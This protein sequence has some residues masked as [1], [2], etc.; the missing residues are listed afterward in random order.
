MTDRT[1]TF[2]EQVELDLRWPTPNEETAE[3]LNDHERWRTEL[4]RLKQA[5]LDHYKFLRSHRAELR[6]PTPGTSSADRA[7]DLDRRITHELRRLERIENRLSWIKQHTMP[8]QH[9][10][11]EAIRR[12]RAWALNNEVEPEENDIALWA[13]IKMEP[14]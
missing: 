6:R 1:T 8:P 7:R 12:H 13:T 10:L 9:A 3:L 11:I 2:E 4:K 14:T 5:S